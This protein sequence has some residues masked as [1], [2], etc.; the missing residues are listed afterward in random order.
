MRRTGGLF[1][2]LVILI[3]MPTFGWWNGPARAAPCSEA[4]VGL[5]STH[6]QTLDEAFLGRA[7]GQVFYAPNTIIQS[8]SV[9]RPAL[10]NSYYPYV[11]LYVTAADSTG[12]PTHPVLQIGPV[13]LPEQ[14]DDG[15]HPVRIN[16]ILDP[17]LVLPRKGLYFFAVK[18]Y[19]CDDAIAVLADSTNGYPE[20]RAWKTSPIWDCSTVGPAQARPPMIDLIFKVVF[21]SDT[22]TAARR[23]SWGQLKLRYR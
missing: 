13:V 1:L 11:I 8:I 14:Y 2:A 3:A 5:D 6:A 12:L 10:Q 7:I 20:G 17:A 23:T 22:T 4:F 16:F 15:I 21:C 19:Y 18:D 9:W